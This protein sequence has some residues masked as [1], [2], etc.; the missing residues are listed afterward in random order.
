MTNHQL[1][2]LLDATEHLIQGIEDARKD[3]CRP[4]PDGGACAGLDF[5]A[6]GLSREAI[7]L[8]RRVTAFRRQTPHVYDA[9]AA[10]TIG[11][12]KELIALLTEARDHFATGNAMA[13]YG[14][15]TLFDHYADDLRAACRLHARSMR[16]PS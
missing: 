11:S 7:D 13:A 9:V 12:T 1:Q 15:L 3:C 6:P 8:Q 4:G 2:D 10:A 5:I 14:T 16:R